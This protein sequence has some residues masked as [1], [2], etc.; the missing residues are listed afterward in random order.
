LYKNHSIKR[1]LEEGEV[2]TWGKGDEGALGL[3]ELKSE[4][5]PKLVPFFLQNKVSLSG[6][7]HF[8]ITSI[9]CGHSHTVAVAGNIYWLCGY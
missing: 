5:L 1:L 2:Y 4:C 7:G 9:T 8:T 3:G 6:F